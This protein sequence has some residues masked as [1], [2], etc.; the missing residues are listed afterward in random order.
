MHKFLKP[1]YFL[2]I[3]WLKQQINCNDIRLYHVGFLWYE[4]ISIISNNQVSG[5]SSRWTVIFKPLVVDIDE[6]DR[7]KRSLYLIQWDTMKYSR[8]RRCICAQL[9]LMI[10]HYKSFD[11]KIQSLWTIIVKLSVRPVHQQRP[12]NQG[13]GQP[14]LSATP[15]LI[16]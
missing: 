11:F 2:F 6:V 14:S 10:F 5:P 16:L 12:L 8:K 15:N 3:H 13:N 1:D 9:C 7:F 4:I